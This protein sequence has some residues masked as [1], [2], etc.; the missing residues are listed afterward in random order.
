MRE[1]GFEHIFSGEPQ[2]EVSFDIAQVQ[3]FRRRVLGRML[4]RQAQ[5]LLPLRASKPAEEMTDVELIEA[6]R[7]NDE[8]EVKMPSIS[9]KRKGAK[10]TY[11]EILDLIDDMENEAIRQSEY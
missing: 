4:I 6:V 8:L 5:I 11:D 1:D 10:E 7:Q 9:E 3:E 2:P